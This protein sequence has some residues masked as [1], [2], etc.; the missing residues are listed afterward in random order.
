MACDLG[1]PTPLVGGHP[2]G[3]VGERIR[4]PGEL[5]QPFLHRA[6]GVAPG[7]GG[8]IGY[9]RMEHWVV[10]G[11]GLFEGSPEKGEPARARDE[12]VEGGMSVGPDP[13]REVIGGRGLTVVGEQLPPTTTHGAEGHDGVGRRSSGHVSSRRKG[14]SA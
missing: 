3:S 14:P 1:R 13:V 9:G 11:E 12:V 4:L 10:L 7:A 8:G 6:R 5:R 2:P